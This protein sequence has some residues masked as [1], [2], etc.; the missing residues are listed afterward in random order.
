[1]ERKLMDIASDGAISEKTP[2]E[3]R[4]LISTM[5]VASQQ[6]GEKPEPIR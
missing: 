4:T 6:F 3:A 5:A 2:R 1:M